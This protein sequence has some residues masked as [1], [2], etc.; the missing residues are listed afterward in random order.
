MNEP[1]VTTVE[2]N[3]IR[4]VVAAERDSPF[5]KR[6]HARNVENP[7]QQ[8][9]RGD[10]WKQMIVCMCTSVQR[11]GP[12]SHGS[13]FVRE[14]PFPLTLSACESNA[15]LCSY[16]ENVLRSRGLR[17]GPKIAKQVGRNLSWLQSGGWQK[18][19]EQF[20]AALQARPTQHG[21]S[22]IA[23]ERQASRA[24]MGRDGGLAGFGPKQARN[25]WQCLG[26]TQYE[27]PLDSRISGWINSIPADFRID[28]KFLYS[29]VP[30]Y[31]SVMSHIQA[32]CD[33]AEVLPCDFDA[34]VFVSVDDDEWPDND[35]VF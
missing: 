3:A 12:T 24:L 29:S 1:V 17:F 9:R 34:S 23:A 25:L 18:V 5:C 32:I 22:R 14:K 33:E 15:N 13:Q 7:P 19:E 30:Y 16:A 26:V 8:F 6:R 21:N 11:S 27:I 20:F 2:V 31:E 4:T 10:F 35:E 28:S